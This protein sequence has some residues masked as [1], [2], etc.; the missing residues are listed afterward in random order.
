MTLEEKEAGLLE[1]LRAYGRVIVAFSGGVDST[2]LA[3]AAHEALGDRALAATARS[4]SYPEA[5]FQEALELAREIGIGHKII[6]TDEI[7]DPNYAANPTNRCYFCKDELFTKLDPLAERLGY[8]RVVYGAIADDAA[9]HRPGHRAAIEHGVASP[10]AAVG[11]TK[12]EIRELSR[13]RS[14]RTWDKPSF[15][16]LSSR[17]AYGHEITREK[18]QTVEAAEQFLRDRGFRAFRVRHHEELARIELG[19][20]EMAR[21][22]EEP[23]RSRLVARLRGLGFEHVTLD[24]AG[25]RSGSMNDVLKLGG[26]APEDPAEHAERLL[27]AQGFGPVVVARHE[28]ILRIT[29]I[30]EAV[31]RLMEPELRDAFVDECRGAGATYVALD[32][33]GLAPAARP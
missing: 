4:P 13:R 27:R 3:A 28:T 8:D 23:L 30:D 18:L 2:Y 33:A 15:A 5:E 19:A 25:F 22:V 9:D 24:L 6:E 21:P 14:L 20:G 10:L 1:L 26:K 11:L 16:C 32:L 7:D 17:F 31:P 12:D 29:L